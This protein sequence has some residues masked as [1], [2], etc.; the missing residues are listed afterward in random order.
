MDPDSDSEVKL[1]WP[2]GGTSSYVNVRQLTRPQ[3]G[4]AAVADGAL[5]AGDRV[6]VRDVPVAEASQLQ[7]GH[8]GWADSMAPMLGREG[9]VS[10]V[11]DDGDVRVHGK[12]WNPALLERVAAAGGT[13]SASPPPRGE[14]RGEWRASSMRQWCKL[15]GDEDGAHSCMWVRKSFARRLVY[16][17]SDGRYKTY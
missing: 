10:S 16:F 15:G 4:A 2:G 14:H 5:A 9:A 3:A 6:R 17:I 11:D 12:C 7:G 1:R 8:G 13:G